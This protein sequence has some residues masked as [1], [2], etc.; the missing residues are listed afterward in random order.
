MHFKEFILQDACA[1]AVKKETANNTVRGNI[2]NVFLDNLEAGLLPELITTHIQEERKEKKKRE[3]KGNK[4]IHSE[5]IFPMRS[6][7]YQHLVRQD[8]ESGK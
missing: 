6:P 3:K 1:S 7:L 2:F 5:N 8:G 4:P